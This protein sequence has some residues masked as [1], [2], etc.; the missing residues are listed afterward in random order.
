MNDRWEPMLHYHQPKS[1]DD[2]LKLLDGFDGKI[3]AGGTDVFPAIQQ[4][5][6]PRHLLDVTSIQ[7]FSDIVVLSNE[8]RIGAAVSWTQ[9]VKADLPKAFDAL[10]QAA[11]EIGSIQIQNAGTI[12]GNICNASPAA[13]S[14]PPLLALDA[15]VELAHVN[16]TR[17]QLPL[18][19]FITGVRQTA[20]DEGE[21]VT[22]IIVPQPISG[23]L[24]AFDKLGSRKYLV[25]S[26]S[27]VAVN[28]A[29]DENGAISMAKIAVGSCSPVAQRLHSLET[30]LIGQSPEQ[31]DV[32]DEHL[33][34]LS[35]IDDVRG[36]KDYR[37]DAVREQ[38]LRAIQRAAVS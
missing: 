9:I 12:A 8:I 15:S 34:P 21:I 27:M 29:L 31:I 3:I 24:S 17:R 22:S 30:A 38:C 11:L 33:A 2:A 6:R 13:D 36:T 18:S 10:K 7:G 23:E 4:G 1:L 35:P 26:I 37:M 20:M 25:I 19:D 16:G 28:L 32:S 14:V 5:S